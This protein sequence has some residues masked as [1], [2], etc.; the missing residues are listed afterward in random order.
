MNVEQSID[1][2][3]LYRAQRRLRIALATVLIAV[4]CL[5]ALIVSW[6]G[7][8]SPLRPLLLVKVSFWALV[9]VYAVGVGAAAIY[10]RWIRRER[11]PL[12]RAKQSDR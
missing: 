12:L 4:T 9:A 10:A 5:F 6:L 1:L 3:P 7:Q 8:D 2:Q 11:E